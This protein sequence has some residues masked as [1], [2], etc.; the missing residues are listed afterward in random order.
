MSPSSAGAAARPSLEV[1]GSALP[2][3]VADALRSAVVDSD[4]GG[5]DAC[6]LTFDDP[7][8]DLLAASGIDLTSALTLRAG[9]AGAEATQ[10]LFDGV[11][12]A[13]GFDYDE[14][15]ATTLVTAYD[16]SYGLFNGLHTTS[17][18]NVNDS[19]LARQVVDLLGLTTGRIDPTPVVHEHISQVNETHF[20]FLTRRAAEVGTVLSVVGDRLSFCRPRAAV[21]AP[22]PG[23]F[24]STGRLQMVPGANLRR[25][26][27][28]VSGAQ[29]VVAVQVRGWDPANKQGLVAQAAARSHAASVTDTPGSVAK[30]FD[31]GNYVRVDLPLD[32]QAACDAAAEALAE[33]IGGCVLHAEGVAYGDPD[34]V[35]GAAVSLGATGRF[36]GRV[37][38]TRARHTWDGA[39][40]RTTFTASGAND[41][42]VL[43]LLTGQARRDRSIGGLAPAVVTDVDDPDGLSR[44]KLRFPW[45]DDCYESDWARVLQL[46]AGAQRGL[47]LLPEIDDEVLVAFEQGDTRRPYV[48]G[49]VFN[50][51]D[52]PPDGVTAGG[53]VVHRLWTSRSGHRV[54][55]DDTDGSEQ[56]T[57]STGQGDVSIVLASSG[58]ITVRGSGDIGVQAGGNLSLQA[59]G[60]AT[61]KA[62]G[63]L[64]LQASAEVTVKGAVIKLN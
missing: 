12:H 34:I 13:L 43:G 56:I 10:V 6:H 64:T 9:P 38:V 27:V 41:R 31:A 16:R 28:R 39:G 3:S 4:A 60:D 19:D 22:E 44:V 21:D 59:T 14:R 54:L 30:A 15:G 32:Q 36:D 26:T 5:P 47:C 46:G 24:G 53:K 58:A 8:R 50:G 25:L 20:D 45:L 52:S 42:S 48:L 62:G 57:V 40:Y 55:L 17:F 23:D 35:A 61:L 63:S 7:G 37:T 51:V 2:S 49:G 1:A 11:V 18:H 33:R 29:Q